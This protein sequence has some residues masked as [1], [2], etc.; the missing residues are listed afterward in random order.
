[1][2]HFSKVFRSKCG[3]G[4]RILNRCPLLFL[5]KCLLI[6]VA[7]H[8]ELMGRLHVCA[9]SSSKVVAMC[10][11]RVSERAAQRSFSDISSTCL[12]GV[13]CVVSGH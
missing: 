5:T 13:G 6:D 2:I 1:M 9:F 10:R 12:R 3:F 11:A 7:V 8:D 4:F